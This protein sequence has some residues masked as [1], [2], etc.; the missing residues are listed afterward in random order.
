MDKTETV[1]VAIW[2]ND[3]WCYADEAELFMRDSGI[4]DDYIIYPV[5]VDWC[6]DDTV[7]QKYAELTNGS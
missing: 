1:F 6:S 7:C 3:C 5:P 4:G 2:P